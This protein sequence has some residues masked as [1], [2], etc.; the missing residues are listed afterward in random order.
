MILAT[1]LGPRLA[2]AV[3][4]LLVDAFA[5]E[6]SDDDWAHCLGGTQAVIVDAGA[7]IAHGAVV[8]RTLWH[9]GRAL[10]CGYVEG[11]AVRADHRGHGRA[12]EV[13][14]AL[15][16]IIRESRDLGALSTTEMALGF[17]VRRGWQ[18]WRGPTSVQTPTGTLRTPEDDGGVLVLPAAAPLDLDAP[19][20]CDW[21]PGDVW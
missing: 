19:L 14:D 15:E 7:P 10:R 9:R 13:M 3:K 17:Y 5:G 18:P 4:A 12:A 16:K 8:P 20:T 1:Q 21:R 11:L 6:F 2:A